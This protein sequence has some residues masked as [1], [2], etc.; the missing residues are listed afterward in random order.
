MGIMRIV[1]KLIGVSR[2]GTGIKPKVTASLFGLQAFPE[3][4]CLQTRGGW[5][6]ANNRGQW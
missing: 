5:T 2:E 6:E 4:M 3:R 1:A